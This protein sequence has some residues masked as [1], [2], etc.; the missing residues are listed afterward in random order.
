MII[1][2]LRT[3][4]PEAEVGLY[5]DEKQLAYITWQAHRQ[6]TE[7]IH[8]K[9]KAILD[10][11]ELTLKSLD[12]IVIYKGPGS[13]TGLRIGFSVAN[14]LA[15]ALQ[16]P[17]VSYAGSDWQRQ[18]VQKLLLGGGEKLVLPDYGAE[19]KTTRQKK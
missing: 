7:T 17:I 16:K 6:L 19:P 18:G 1:L 12:G 5:K 15:D 13:F 11:K 10:Y 8:L 14:A 4:K 9:I 2:T 3:D